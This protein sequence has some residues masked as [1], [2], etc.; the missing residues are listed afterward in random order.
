MLQGIGLGVIRV[1]AEG[2]TALD[3]GPI[4]ATYRA[5]ARLP[6]PKHGAPVPLSRLRERGQG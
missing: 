6:T 5:T 2:V 1:H 3:L 4:V